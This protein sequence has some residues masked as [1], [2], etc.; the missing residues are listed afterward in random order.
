MIRRYC[1]DNSY[2]SRTVFQI[3]DHFWAAKYR[4]KACA[5]EIPERVGELVGELRQAFMIRIVKGVVSKN[6]LYVLMICPLSLVP[7]KS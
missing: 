6:Y 1:M 5:G 4:Y 7:R 3:E 2:D